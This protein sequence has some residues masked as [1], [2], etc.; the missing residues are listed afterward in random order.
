MKKEERFGV[1]ED[2]QYFFFW[3]TCFV[4]KLATVNIFINCVF[5]QLV[6]G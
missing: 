4:L 6:F 3:A 5:Y 2:G 1:R